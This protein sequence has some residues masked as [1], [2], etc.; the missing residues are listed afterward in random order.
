MLVLLAALLSLFTFLILLC[1][2][3]SCCCAART[4]DE[5]DD[6]EKAEATMKSL[7]LTLCAGVRRGSHADPVLPQSAP[8][9]EGS[10][11]GQTEIATPMTQRMLTAQRHRKLSL[12]SCTIVYGPCHKPLSGPDGNLVASTMQV[13]RAMNQTMHISCE[14][15]A[16]GAL[17]GTETQA[18]GPPSYDKLIVF[19]GGNGKQVETEPEGQ[20]EK[21]VSLRLQA[22]IDSTGVSRESQIGIAL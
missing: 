9:Q 12:C 22:H 6:L 4:N 16:E 11:D 20:K 15:A 21:E 10:T 14:E 19:G 18:D 5:D 13:R 3:V 1:F 17:Q 7:N 2:C 8:S